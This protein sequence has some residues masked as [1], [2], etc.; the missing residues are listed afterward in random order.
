MKNLNHNLRTKRSR[1]GAFS[2]L[3]LLVVLTVVGLLLS[4]AAPN[5]FSL[6]QSRTLS[7]E[8]SLLRNQLTFAQQIAVS[9]NADVEVRF[10]KWRDESAAEE[11]EQFSA[12]QL[13]Q[14]SNGGEMKPISSFFRIKAPTVIY[15]EYSTL[16]EAGKNQTSTDRKY[17]F[18]SPVEGTG[19]APTGV[20]DSLQ[21][22]RYVSFRFR[23]DGSTDLPNKSD[24]RDTWY[25]TLV[26]GEGIDSNR[27]PENYVCLQV[28]P[29]NGAVSQ[30]R[31]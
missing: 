20:L 21:D 12:F 3:E 28:N 26:Q 15:E 16:L 6:V 5:L 29:Y 24:D 4:F 10:Y 23:P 19:Q 2:L 18:V 13:F 14:Y 11:D 7:N 8:G 1:K 9:K 30:F 27:L 31:P 22:T 17:G 25:I